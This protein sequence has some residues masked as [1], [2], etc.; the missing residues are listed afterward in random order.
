M[1][2]SWYY[3]VKFPA[4]HEINGCPTIILP[5]YSTGWSRTVGFKPPWSMPWMTMSADWQTDL[6]LKHKNICC[7]F[8]KQIDAYYFK[9]RCH[10]PLVKVNMH[11]MLSPFP[12]LIPWSIFIFSLAKTFQTLYMLAKEIPFLFETGLSLDLGVNSRTF[13]IKNNIAL[14]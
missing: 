8:H 4:V 2:Y 5:Y 11:L 6:V 10:Q 3:P 9:G 12:A 7:L 1:Q 14:L 13:L